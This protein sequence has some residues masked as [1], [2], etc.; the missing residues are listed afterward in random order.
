MFLWKSEASA[1]GTLC[2]IR[3][4]KVRCTAISYI[5]R[6][7]PL[8]DQRNH[9][10][11]KAP[12]A[13]HF[14]QFWRCG[15]CLGSA[16]QFMSVWGQLPAIKLIC[17]VWDFYPWTLYSHARFFSVSRLTGSRE[18]QIDLSRRSISETGREFAWDL[19]SLGFAH[20]EISMCRFLRMSQ[21]P[22]VLLE[23]IHVPITKA[24]VVNR[25]QNVHESWGFV[26]FKLAEGTSSTNSCIQMFPTMGVPF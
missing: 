9:P 15:G 10:K 7:W 20:T 24:R 18:N 14:R 3:L 22:Q 13:E 21:W 12:F 8:E 25:T 1:L 6:Q 11:T 17:E 16:S 19:Q 2:Q 4:P 23:G 5:P 26:R